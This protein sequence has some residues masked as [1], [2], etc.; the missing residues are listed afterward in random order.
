MACVAKNDEL[1]IPGTLRHFPIANPFHIVNR[2]NPIAAL[3]SFGSGKNGIS[4]PQLHDESQSIK[5][6][7]LKRCCSQN[8]LTN[9]HMIADD[10][11]SQLLEKGKFMTFP[12]Q[13]KLE[14][15]K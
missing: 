9:A 2:T 6:N 7:L 5:R 11:S 15:A 13:Q 4:T 8:T 3:F 12:G 14:I 10:L 1:G